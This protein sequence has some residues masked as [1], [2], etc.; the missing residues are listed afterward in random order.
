M[1]IAKLNMDAQD[2]TRFE[3]CGKSS[4]KYHLKA[5]HVVEAK[6]WFWSL[7]NA[8]QFTKDEAREDEKRKAKDAESLLQARQEAG[9]KTR[10]GS[11]ASNM[12]SSKAAGL[13]VPPVFPTGV[14]GGSRASGAASIRAESAFGDDTGSMY[15]SYEASLTAGDL[16]RV[17]TNAERAAHVFDDEQDEDDRSSTNVQPVNKDAFSITAQSAKF[18]LDLLSRVS[19]ALGAEAS[20]NPDKMISDPTILKA[21]STYEA[22]VGSLNSLVVDLLKI[23]RDRDAYWQYRLEKEA[24]DRKIW[25]ESLAW[26]AQEQES[27]QRTVDESEDKRKRTKRALR[28]A[29][30]GQSAAASRPASGGGALDHVQF[31]EALDTVPVNREGR[32]SMHKKSVSS[33]DD[34]RKKSVIAQYT[35]ISDSESGDDEE[36]FDAVDAGEVP[37]VPGPVSPPPPSAP[38]GDA[39]LDERD[40]KVKQIAASYQ[41]YE[42]PIRTR[43]KMDSDNRPKISLWGI[44]KSMIGKDMTKMTLPVSFNEPTSLL[45]RIAEDMEYADLLDIAA[46]RADSAERMVYVAAFASSNYSSTIGRVA[47]PFNPLLGETFE[48]VRP[49]KGYRFLAEQVSH[50]PPI[51]AIHA[52]SAN[53]DYFGESAVQSKFY[54]KTFDINHLGVWFLRLR[55]TA[56][57]PTELYTWKKVTASVVGIITGNPTIDNYGPMEVKNWTTGEVCTLDFRQRGW[58]ASSAYQVSGKVTGDDMLTKWSIGGRWSDK[59]YGRLTPGFEDQRVSEAGVGTTNIAAAGSG[60]QAILLWEANPRPS[61][62]PFNLTPFVITLNALPDRLKP[63]LAPTDTRLRPDQRAM[64]EGEYDLAAA[65]KQRV[66]E[67]QRSARRLRD[68]SGEEWRPKWFSKDVDPVTGFSYW[69]AN[70]DYWRRRTNAANGDAA[71]EGWEGVCD[72]IF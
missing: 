8:I 53:W 61:G 34:H 29:L 17:T 48:Y 66:E 55:P 15:G 63:V 20:K 10:S 13:A 54:G 24:D 33:R 32:A 18:Q 7:N 65:E 38:A 46:E 49:E 22:A 27:L 42:D 21:L 72:D 6:R 12:V 50:H 37:V 26:I 64:E 25:E 41:G 44:L 5:N 59:I 23:S 40:A 52:E 9:E 70:G 69:K 36:F 11:D 39:V 67:K 71:A 14:S 57:G 58:K 56:G 19:E 2:K 1:R 62:I 4:V 3:I 16:S 30:E 47:K 35:N 68:S 28:D 43:L 31:A 60:D 45:Q 51:G